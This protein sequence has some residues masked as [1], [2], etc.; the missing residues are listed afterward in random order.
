[1]TSAVRLVPMDPSGYERFR[2][3]LVREY[4]TDK[5]AA[6]NWPAEGSLER[7]QTEMHELLPDG[8]ATPGNWLWTIEDE[9]GRDVGDLWIGPHASDR[10]AV[11]IFDIEVRPEARGRGIGRAA[12]DAL[13]AW[14]RDA[15]YP[16][17]GLQV[18]GSNDVAR[19]LYARAGYVETNVLMEKR[20]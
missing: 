16:R 12:L 5:V 9:A 7:S 13:D 15:G 3:R 10:E 2:T 4:A 6:G 1:M 17:I 20:L 18:F 11:Y 14:A 19:R 8:L